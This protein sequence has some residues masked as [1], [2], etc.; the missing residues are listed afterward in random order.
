MGFSLL[1]VTNAQVAPQPSSG[2]AKCHRGIEPIREAG[3]QM[4][5]EILA[6]G[7]TLGDPA[8][9]VVC[10]GGDPAAEDKQAAHAGRAF[11][12]DPG[13]PWINK[14][15]CGQCHPKQ[16]AT[17]WHSLMMTEAGKIQGTAWAFG[18]LTGYE[19][20]WGNYNVENPKD[21]KSR[22]GTDDYRAYMQRL[23]KL[24]PLVFV[25]RHEALPDAPTDLAELADHPELAAFTY[26]RNQCERCHHAVKGRQVRGDYRGMGCSGCHI[27]YGNEGHYEGGDETIARD[28]PGHCLVHSIQ[29]TREAK[30]VVH[31]RQYSGIPVETCTTCHDRGKRIGVTFQGLME[32]PYESPYV[33]DGAGQPA[34]HTKHYIAMHQ[35]VHYQKGM[36]CQD[37]HTS[38]DV[39]SDGF[40][41]ACNL[42][43]VEIECSDCHGTPEA[44]PWELPLGFMD[45][46][47]EAPAE[48]PARGTAKEL[49]AHFQQGTV[50]Q[51]KDGYLR[52]ARGNPFSNAVRDGDKV[53]VHTAAGKDIELKPLKLIETR[54][55]LSLAGLVAMK[56]ARR[57][58]RRME[59]YTCH[60][61]W[62][63]Q[64]YGCHVKIDY[65]DGK[66]CFD[67]VAAGR[68]HMN[69]EYAAVR[70]EAD[71][72]TLIPGQI[73]E[74]RSFLRWEDPAMGVNGEGRITPVAPGCQVSATVI[75]ADGKPILLNHIFRTLPESEG[76]GP[77]GQLSL[78]MSPTQPHTMTK[79]ARACESCH[80]S[81]KALGHG[82]GSGK[83]TR[84]PDRRVVVDLETVDGHILPENHK[85]QM[86]A[87]DGLTAD[88]SRFVTEEGKQLQTVGHHLKGSRPL[89][90]EERG[91]IDRQGVCLAC[92]QEIP[93][94][95]LAVNLLHHVAEYT[96]QLPKSSAQHGSLIHKIMLLSGWV[97]VAG[98]LAVPLVGLA[99]IVWYRRR[100]RRR[101]AAA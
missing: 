26:I 101:K 51:V 88:W 54:K 67:W 10:H 75:G 78:D 38:F 73:E 52:T 3:S 33:E 4:A 68:R 46:F 69:P 23:R 47:Q 24:E 45:E 5:D 14:K 34:L 50:Y 100:K 61:A 8:G 28:K 21:P 98:G 39:H 93:D 12:G 55:K 36:I 97:Q 37:C 76:S 49:L 70:G 64:C 43:A 81:Q 9:C 79:D 77:E 96:G 15:T 71:F 2:C 66:T 22:L 1:A 56:S 16:V 30:V 90:N 89:N 87:I 99:A 40:L 44:F 86:A 94:R 74:Q 29:A 82:I 25:D 19:H 85:T 91:H 72:H 6:W 63:P 35:D 57:H 59:C 95:S 84:P 20:K 53:I 11:Y 42:G 18:S 48:G 17:Q 58:I 41:A 65:S 7:E 60:A 31:G 62:A 83:L 13:S 80:L 27:P 92:H 32:T